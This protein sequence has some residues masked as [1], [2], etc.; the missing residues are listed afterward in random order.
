MTAVDELLLRVQRLEHSNRRLRVVLTVLAL[1]GATILLMGTVFSPVWHG[2][3]ER[4][5][6]LLRTCKSR[7]MLTTVGAHCPM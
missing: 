2:V 7:I 6:T 4:R 3:F 5:A 1:G